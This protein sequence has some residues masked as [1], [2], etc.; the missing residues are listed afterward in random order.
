MVK[1]I[2]ILLII[3]A[4]LTGC[5]TQ[6]D[7]PP[8]SPAQINSISGDREEVKDVASIHNPEDIDENSDWEMVPVG[9]SSDQDMQQPS[10][11][12][13]L[14]QEQAIRLFLDAWEQNDL[15]K[16]NMLTQQP[17][18]EF[19]RQSDMNFVSYRYL[20]SGDL[21]TFV[22]EGMSKIREYS[23][24]TLDSA[25][26]ENPLP[27]GDRLKVSL[28]DYLSFNVTLVLDRNMWK[29]K[30]MSANISGFEEAAPQDW[31]TL[32]QLVLTD[33]KDM[34]G[35]GNYELLTMGFSG[36]WEGI[37]PE[38]TS[39]I[40]VYTC[41]GK[42]FENLYFRDMY[43][44]LESDRVVIEGGIGKVMEDEPV[45]LVLIEK[46]AQD[47]MAIIEGS[48]SQY[49]VSLYKLE[50]KH[51]I[52]IGEMDWMSSVT[53]VLD[54]G[55]IP[56]WVELLGVKGLKGDALESVVLR[57]GLRNRQDR[58]DFYQTNEGIFVMSHDGDEWY[59]DWYHE[60]TYGEYHTVVFEEAGPDN[61]P[62]KMYYIEDNPYETGQGG[63]VFEVY[64]RRGRWNEN[65]LFSEKLNI[66]AAGDMTGN[67]TAEFLVFD[68]LTLK[69][70]SKE[71]EMLW[72]VTLPRDT[73][74]IP[75]AWIGSTAGKQRIIAALHMGDYVNMNSGVYV[76]E[77]QDGMMYNS[78]QS[79]ALGTDGIT[80]MMVRDLNKDGKPE[81]LVNYTN[82]Y[83]VWGQFF[84]IFEP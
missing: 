5:S 69:V 59:T 32:G 49:Y 58:D 64:Y 33:I 30:A 72:D 3:T 38:P 54:E 13:L 66:K 68:G 50:N 15:E 46:T 52:K 79:E 78:W 43:N 25:K 62:A 73:K 34:D 56:E 57:V 39:A 12:V 55:I 6:I 31:D 19:F 67:G 35:D 71:R 27:K 40:G 80:A 48:V 11:S 7:L 75:Y 23:I 26:I 28:G 14:N 76:W 53:D 63:S 44:R 65:R 81:V 8:K 70:Y 20:D 9:D 60:G 21:A 45:L 77:E 84:K 82:D 24:D 36:E 22:R 51:L 17:L 42:Q 10:K 16:M 37:G 18:E 2:T 29:L 4:L 1:K 61:Q 41:T 47:N 83:L 74:E